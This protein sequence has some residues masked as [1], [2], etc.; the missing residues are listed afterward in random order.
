MSDQ[1]FKEGAIAGVVIEKLNQHVDPR[2]NLVELFR[3]DILAS[4]AQ[5]PMAYI[6]FTLPNVAR[7]PHEHVEQTDRFIFLTAF[8]VYLWDARED[9]ITY[10]NK[11]FF[12]AEAFSQVTIPPG[13]V[14]GYKNIEKES[15]V[16]LNL[17]N[18][19]Y[20]GY[21]KEDPVDE[22]RHEQDEDSPYRID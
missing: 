1:I 3:N 7:G 6:S 11:L 10:G 19:L 13:V 16:V 20:A 17:P 22:I 18:K 8:K 21:G 15:G 9:S 14:H 12:T 5:P 4:E 2:G